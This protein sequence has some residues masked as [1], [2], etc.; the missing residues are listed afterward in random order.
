MVELLMDGGALTALL[1]GN[2]ALLGWAVG[3]C[4]EVLRLEPGQ[5]G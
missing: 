2:W 1:W 4:G 3:S 5:R